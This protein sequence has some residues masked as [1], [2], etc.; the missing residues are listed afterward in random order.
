MRLTVLLLLTCSLAAAAAAGGA[1]R[2]DTPPAPGPVTASTFLV[3]GRGY[4]HGVGMSQYGALGFARAGKNHDEIL[5]YYYP[6]TVLGRA[7]VATIRVLLAEARPGVTIS[8]PVPFQVKDAA[9][10]TLDLD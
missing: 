4:G 9:G 2:A 7:P 10:T 3:M 1:S 5:A 6:G 8:S